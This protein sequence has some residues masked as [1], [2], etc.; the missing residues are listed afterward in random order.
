MRRALC[1]ITFHVV[2][3]DTR[4]AIQSACGNVTTILACNDDGS[5]CANSGS[6][7]PPVIMEGGTTYYIALG[8]KECFCECVWVLICTASAVREPG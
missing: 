6:V 5:N 2:Q 1:P 8:G 4:I 7:S 3:P